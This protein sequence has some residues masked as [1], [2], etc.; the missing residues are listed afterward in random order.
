MIVA[1]S[2]HLIMSMTCLAFSIY[3]L[4]KKQI[5]YFIN[6]IVGLVFSSS[7]ILFYLTVALL[8]LN[9]IN[10]QNW[11]VQKHKPVLMF[12]NGLLKKRSFFK[13]INL[14]INSASTPIDD[15]NFI[16]I[17]FNNFHSVCF[18]V[19]KSTNK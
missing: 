12:G 6:T 18:K 11:F 16:D 14:R 5:T 10:Y 4:K 1:F 8:I 7:V 19:Y 3:E 15:S 17:S 9:L 2:V 13:L